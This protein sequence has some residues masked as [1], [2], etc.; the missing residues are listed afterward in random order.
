MRLYWLPGY[1]PELNPSE[2]VWREVKSHRDGEPGV[3]SLA[4]MKS[5]AMGALRHLARRPDKIRSLF[6]TN[7]TQYAA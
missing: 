1:S 3:F 6:H 7:D 4:D 5:K 2:G